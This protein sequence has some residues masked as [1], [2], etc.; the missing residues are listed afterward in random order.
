MKRMRAI[1]KNGQINIKTVL[2]RDE[3]INEKELYIFESRMLRGFMKP[4]ITGHNKIEYITPEGVSLKE[5]LKKGISREEFFLIIIQVA[6]VFNTIEHHKLTLSSLV[7]DSSIIFINESTKL[8]EFI[9]QPIESNDHKISIFDFYFSIISTANFA[10]NEDLST[11]YGLRDL[12]QKMQFYSTDQ[13]ENYILEVCPG[14]Y[15]YIKNL[16][17]GNSEMLYSTA[18][19]KEI[20]EVEKGEEETG[21][22]AEEAETGLLD[23]EP[24]TGLLNDNLRTTLQS[25]GGVVIQ[26][27]GTDYSED[28]ETGTMLLGLEGTMLLNQAPIEHI[29]YAY[30]VRTKTGEK[31]VINK[32]DYKIGRDARYTDMAITDNKAVSGQHATIVCR[33]GEYFVIDNNSTNSTYINGNMI[34]PREEK[35]I[36][37]GDNVIFG[38]EG[39][40]FLIE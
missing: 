39:F 15:K 9:Y 38:N 29:Q 33:N 23:E 20:A 4:I 36:T 27:H 37:N 16:T 2:G 30:L 22:L 26:L 25:N 8:L 31:F 5:F 17:R 32:T 19:K 3:K 1:R 6:E 14:P 18:I 34:S 12:L 28:A 13:I 11:V 21:L 24:E 40:N 7:M 35:K 10:Q